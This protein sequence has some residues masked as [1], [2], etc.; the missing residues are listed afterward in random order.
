VKVHAPS[1]LK[2]RWWRWYLRKVALKRSDTL[3]L[4][5]LGAC[6]NWKQSRGRGEHGR[7]ECELSLSVMGQYKGEPYCIVLSSYFIFYPSIM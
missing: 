3:G 4:Q 7:S 5:K 1:T 6:D 2:L